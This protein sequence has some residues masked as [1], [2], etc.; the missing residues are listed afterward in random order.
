MV[1]S[2]YSLSL[3]VLTAF[4]SG[5]QLTSPRIIGQFPASQHLCPWVVTLPWIQVLLRGY[6]MGRVSMLPLFSI[7]NYAIDYKQNNVVGIYVWGVLLHIILFSTSDYCIYYF[8]Y[9]TDIFCCKD[10]IVTHFKILLMV[11]INVGHVF[12]NWACFCVLCLCC[13]AAVLC[14][15]ITLISHLCNNKFLNLNNDPYRIN[16]GT[17]SS[18]KRFIVT[19]VI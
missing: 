18:L 4:S 1:Y 16:D 6:M 19:H 8:I 7:Q 2:V 11:K 12:T 9:K 13:S 10:I 5:T 3:H 15:L 14:D 17:C